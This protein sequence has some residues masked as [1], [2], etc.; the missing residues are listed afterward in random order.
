MSNLSSVAATRLW[1]VVVVILVVLGV[2]FLFDHRPVARLP[3]TPSSVSNCPPSFTSDANGVLMLSIGDGGDLWPNLIHINKTNRYISKK[4]QKS[5]LEKKN[6]HKFG[7]NIKN[8]NNEVPEV[9]DLTDDSN[10]EQVQPEAARV[11]APSPENDSNQD[12]NPD[13]EQVSPDVTQAQAPPQE[14]SLLN[15]RNRPMLP[16]KGPR[17]MRRNRHQRNFY[18]VNQDHEQVPPE[19]AQARAPPPKVSLPNRRNQPM[20]FFKDA[21][22][23]IRRDRESLLPEGQL[24]A[25]EHHIQQ[26]PKYRISENDTLPEHAGQC[27]IC[28]EEFSPGDMRMMLHCFHA[29]HTNCCTEWLRINGSCPICKTRIEEN[30]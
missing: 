24:A 16:I 3:T 26:L 12:V 11:R 25:N 6:R 14:V 9:I 18:D 2:S 7:K 30:F 10:H 20:L 21:R 5:I 13:D 17:G 15:R 8:S 27:A 22:R 19:A 28:L 4:N 29:F 23:G 1:V